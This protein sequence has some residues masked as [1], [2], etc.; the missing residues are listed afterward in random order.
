MREQ[1]IFF[2]G[3]IKKNIYDYPSYLELFFMMRL[4]SDF[5]FFFFFF[6]FH[7]SSN[8]KKIFK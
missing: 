6:F 4:T 7:C 2:D 3:E 1:N 8:L 5:F